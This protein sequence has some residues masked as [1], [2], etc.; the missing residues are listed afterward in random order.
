MREGG[1]KGELGEDLAVQW[2]F[3]FSREILLYESG[4]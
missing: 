4:H 1:Y 3:V 2:D